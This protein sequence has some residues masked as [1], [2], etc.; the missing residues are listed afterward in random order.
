MGNHIM[1]TE[2]FE[3]FYIKENKKLVKKKPK[4]H[5]QKSGYFGIW[6]H[7]SCQ[8]DKTNIMMS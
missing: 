5:L 2:R 4:T 6:Y 7:S 8:E 1:N 3:A